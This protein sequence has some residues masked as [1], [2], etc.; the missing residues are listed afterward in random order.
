MTVILVLNFLK[1]VIICFFTTFRK[2]VTSI[3]VFDFL[4]SV[5][6]FSV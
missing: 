1:S 6:V 2:S 3:L 4:K 5:A